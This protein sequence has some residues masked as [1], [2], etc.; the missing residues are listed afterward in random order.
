[1]A[2]AETIKGE[3]QAS[4]RQHKIERNEIAE[5]RA[6]LLRFLMSPESSFLV[7]QRDVIKALLPEIKAAREMGV[8]FERVAELLNG[9]GIRLKADTIREYYFEE[10][11]QQ[12]QEAIHETALRYKRAAEE[13]IQRFQAASGRGLD[14][15]V[16]KAVDDAASKKKPA[17]TPVPVS[18]APVVT[19]KASSE[20]DGDK[21]TE[22]ASVPKNDAA[23]SASPPA[24]S[25]K[26]KIP[27][28]PARVVSAVSEEQLEKLLNT[29]FDPKDIPRRPL[30]DE[31]EDEN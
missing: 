30:P 24:V 10:I 11:R 12:D 27:P 15:I 3:N 6:E 25:E 17:A 1:M 2:V 26:A 8:G 5:C 20:S 14:E 21:K 9:K 7:R 19:S 31:F 13:A 18:P 4:G 29:H 22:S 16:K 28:S 23:R